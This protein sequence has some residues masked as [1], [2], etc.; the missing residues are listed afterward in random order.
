VNAQNKQ[1]L[2]I[3]LSEPTHE[4]PVSVGATIIDGEKED[5][6]VIVMKTRIK[7]GYHIYA[8]VPPSEA[9]IKTEQGIEL[10]EGVELLGE[11]EKSAPAS[12][13]GNNQLLIYKKENSFKHKI[14]IGSNVASGLS[15]KC[16]LYYQ[17]CNASIC[18]P[19]KKKE[20]VLEL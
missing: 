16:W 9:Y 8:Y 17:S 10:P 20:F 6:K 13:P 14:K 7:D 15:I 4:D 18:L 3:Q 19:P 2:N 12:Y 11:W 5:E 1:T